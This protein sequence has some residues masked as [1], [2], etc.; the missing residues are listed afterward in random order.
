VYANGEKMGEKGLGFVDLFTLGF[1]AIVGVGWSIT[2]NNLYINGGG[3]VAAATGFALGTVLLIPI[4]LCFAELTPAMPVAGGVTAYAYRAYGPKLSFIA[5]WFVAMAYISILPWEAIAINDILSFVIPW[6]KDGP[7]LYQIYGQKIFLHSA[8]IGVGT[9]AMI[10]F[11]NFRGIRY[12]AK[13]Q[14]IMTV[15]LL[16]GSLICIAAALLKFDIRNILPVYQSMK[17]KKHTS[18]L[19]GILTMLAMAPFYFS[20]FDTIPQGAEE[21][22]GIKPSS[23]GKVIILVLVC[24]G[25]F[26]V[27]IFLSAG[28][29][30]PWLRFI[31]L[32]RPAFPNLFLVLYPNLFGKL[33]FGISLISAL[34]GLF[35][36]WNGFYIAGSRLLLG[37]ARAQFLP[38]V[39]KK[40]HPKYKTPYMCDAFCAAIMVLGVFLGTGIIDTLTTLGSAGFVVGW[41]ITCISS[42][43]LRRTAPAMSRP[44]RMRYG[45]FTS[46]LGSGVCVL[47]LLNC[48]IPAMPGYMGHGGMIALIAW[49]VLGIIFFCFTAKKRTLS[50]EETAHQLFTKEKASIDG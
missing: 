34:A 35:S 15:L 18:F 4:S 11:L 45:E 40:V 36:T 28:C 31:E 9:A 19:S 17:M 48:V 2:L 12:A 49:S 25:C 26:Y 47:I 41:G 42:Y 1:G 3:P 50:E 13:F 38:A 8:I 7:V 39:F 21:T 46:I 37:M 27:S 5:G 43:K 33:L 44:Y 24:A 29:A 22:E 32:G 23:I 20:G 16:G 30:L 14:T 10:V 6:A